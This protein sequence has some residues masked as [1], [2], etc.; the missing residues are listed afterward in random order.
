MA[1]QDR[2]KCCTGDLCKHKNL[3]F[4][5]ATSVLDVMSLCTLFVQQNMPKQISAGAGSVCKIPCL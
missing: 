1:T 5:R 4:A 3:S 2:G